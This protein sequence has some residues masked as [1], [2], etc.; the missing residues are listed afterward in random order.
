[1]RR[2]FFAAAFATTLATPAA[3]QIPFTTGAPVE[4]IGPLGKDQGGAY[5]VATAQMFQ[6]PVG[7]NYLQS[8]TFFLSNW[9]IGNQL[10]L[11]AAIYEFDADR[12]T[13]PAL[14]MSALFPGTSNDLTPEAYT[15]GDP[16]APLNVQL[17]PALTYA[18]VLSTLDDMGASTDGAAVQVGVTGGTTYGGIFA[19]MNGTPTADLSAPGT[20]VNVGNDQA[21]TAIFTEGRVT[22]TPEPA[23]LALLATGF[24]GL[25]GW[26]ARRRRRQHAA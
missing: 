2:F 10:F 8:F 4:T 6:V 23:T 13:G 11:N 16:T 1:M 9:F 19:V 20:F 7:A 17:F 5:A 3:A 14:F 18:L 22:A 25:G 21:I 12:I 15:F 26:S 24:A